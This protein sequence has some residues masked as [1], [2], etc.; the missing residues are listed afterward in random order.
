[1]RYCSLVG[2]IAG[3]GGNAIC[4]VGGLVDAVYNWWGSN[5]NPKDQIYEAGSSVYYSPWLFMTITASPHNIGYSDTSV[6]MVSF[7]N[8]STDGTTYTSF[9]PSNG[10]IPDGTVVNLSTDLGSLNP[11]N[12]V[13]NDGIATS[14]FTGSRL[15]TATVTATTDSQLVSTNINVGKKDTKITVNDIKGT[16][17]DAVTLKA[18]LTDIDGNVLKD[19]TVI[20]TVNGVDYSAITGE[21]GVASYSY[22]LGLTPAPYIITAVFNGDD[23]YNRTSGIGTLTVDK[24]GTTIN[25]SNVTGT[26]GGNVTLKATL[27]DTNGNP[28]KNKAV[29]FMVNG[30]E[31]SVTTDDDGVASYSYKIGLKPGK[32]TMSARF[33]GDSYYMGCNNSAGL[34]VKTA[35][36]GWTV[37]DKSGYKSNKIALIAIL[38]DE[39]GKALTGKTVKFIVS[40]DNGVYIAFT[41]SSGQAVYKNY[42]INQ[43][44]GIYTITAKFL[45]DAYYGGSSESG[46]LTVKPSAYLSFSNAVTSGFHYYGD[47]VYYYLTVKNSGPDNAT[48]VSVYDKLPTGL[49]YRGS[50]AN[51]GYYQ[52]TGNWT[53]GMLKTGHTATLNIK[54]VINKVGT[55]KNTAVLTEKT[56]PTKTI[57][58]SVSLTAPAIITIPQLIAGSKQIKVYYESHHRL[59]G[60]ISI[61]GQTLTMP[62]LLKLVAIATINIYNRNL[63]PLKVTAVGNPPHP[64]GSYVS[65]NLYTQQYIQLALNIRNF[66]DNTRIAP[67]YLKTTLGQIP[68]SKLVY[69]YSKIITFYGKQHRLPNYAYTEKLS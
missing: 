20:F 6:V 51:I 53:I 68:F 1:M 30:V 55:I 56:Y 11:T 2:N 64:Q 21:D 14:I 42:V 62:Q 22:I 5:S 60:S 18:T 3:S 15:G 33:V 63:N 67:N 38:K 16:Y 32:Y 61:A 49:I 54:A 46:S 57:K 26:Y 45:G 47:T 9:D 8:Y 41:N 19:K 35:S 43:K 52:S 59:P 31:Y 7:N 66:I 40:G 23:Y 36:T 25:V 50:L 44:S 4:S 10:H 39:Y 69:I 12:T 34:D 17:G 28:L 48:G 29:T 37:V 27:K 58:K 24:I 65:G 13:T